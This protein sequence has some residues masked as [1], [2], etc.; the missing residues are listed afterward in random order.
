MRVACKICERDIIPALQGD[1]NKTVIWE[2]CPMCAR[3]LKALAEQAL[4]D[5]AIYVKLPSPKT[6]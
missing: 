6:T 5:E 4:Q 1:K 3:T 2:T